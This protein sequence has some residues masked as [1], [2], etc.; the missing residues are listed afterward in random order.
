MRET[1]T[2]SVNLSHRGWHVC[3]IAERSE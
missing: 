2:N 1:A 3:R